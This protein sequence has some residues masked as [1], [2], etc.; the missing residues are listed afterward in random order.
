M[1]KQ[2]VIVQQ[3]FARAHSYIYE[4]RQVDRSSEDRKYAP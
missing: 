2:I 3:L 1:V 4:G